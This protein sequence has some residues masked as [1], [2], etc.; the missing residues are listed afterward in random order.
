MLLVLFYGVAKG[1]RELLKKKAMT[2]NS[3][4]DVLIFYTFLSFLMVVPEVRNA[5]GMEPIFYLHIAI[6]SLCIFVAWICS[7]K[8][9]DRL[10]ISLYGV[11]DLSRVLF[12]TLLGILFLH[13]RMTPFRIAGLLLVSMGLLML[14]YRP[15]FL[16]RLLGTPSV[17]EV[18][19]TVVSQSPGALHISKTTLYVIM[20]FVSCI[21]N[22]VSGLYDKILMKDLTSD[23]L[24]FWYMAFLMLY[25]VIYMIFTKTKI[26]VSVVKNGWI[27]ALAILFVVADRALF[28]ANGMA[29][30]QITV[31]TLIKQSGAIVTILAGKFIFKEKN[32]RDKLFCAVI[33]ILGIV[34]GVM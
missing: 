34:L 28:I 27:W 10:P 23:Q 12:S 20:A 15:R 7:F 2:K 18:P 13:E 6:K 32:V 30:S 4:M 1:T 11:L 33:I 22:A 3:M 21:L 31:M 14:K 26:N 17:E 9:I 19:E 29:E 25:Y 24:Q 5:G 16:N 8:A